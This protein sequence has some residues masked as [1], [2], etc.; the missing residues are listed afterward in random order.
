M[1]TFSIKNLHDFFLH[2]QLFYVNLAVNME[3]ER[4]ILPMAYIHFVSIKAYQ[5]KL[6]PI[7]LWSLPGR[8]L[9]NWLEPQE[10]KIEEIS[11]IGSE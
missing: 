5:V 7:T 4:S 9:A 3:N 8:R 11:L 2:Y 10:K 6:W 1:P